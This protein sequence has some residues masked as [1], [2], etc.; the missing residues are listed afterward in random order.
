MFVR[1]YKFW[2]FAF[3]YQSNSHNLWIQ[4]QWWPYGYKTL[5][6]AWSVGLW[7]VSVFFNGG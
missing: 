4:F 1:Q 2:K 5:W 3:R 6:P 7:R